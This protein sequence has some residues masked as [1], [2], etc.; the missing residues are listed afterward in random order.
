[1]DEFDS[2][3]KYYLDTIIN[4]SKE[5]D[6]DIVVLFRIIAKT[7]SNSKFDIKLNHDLIK[8]QEVKSRVG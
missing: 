8:F 1:M 6:I 7:F 5:K 4:S 2:H 3:K